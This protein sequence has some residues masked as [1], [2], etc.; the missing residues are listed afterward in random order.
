M[1]LGLST[2]VQISNAATYVTSKV[3][4]LEVA[5]ISGQ[6]LSHM[7]SPC[8][9]GVELK[10]DIGREFTP[11]MVLWGDFK[12][13]NQG[14]VVGWGGAFVLRD[15]L[16]KVGYKGELGENNSLTPEIIAFLNNKEFIRLSYLSGIKEGGRYRYSDWNQ[17]ASVEEGATGLVQRFRHSVEQ[18]YPRNYH[19]E[20]VNNDGTSFP[21][22][23]TPLGEIAT[24]K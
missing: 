5:D 24:F 2:G 23:T 4:I 9:I 1:K 20:L 16:T 22:V 6:Q 11:T 13:D 8:D 14:N 15:F 17:V 3:K 10:I 12:R 21:S 18:G 19:P 7:K